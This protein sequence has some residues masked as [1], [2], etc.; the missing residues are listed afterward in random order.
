MYMSAY[1]TYMYTHMCVCVI[2]YKMT[3]LGSGEF[4]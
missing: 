3:L 4:H 1:I 2:L